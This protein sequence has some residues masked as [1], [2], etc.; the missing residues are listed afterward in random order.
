MKYLVQISLILFLVS[1]AKDPSLTAEYSDIYVLKI[2]KGYPYPIIPSDNPMTK[3]KIAL[4]KK[5][6]F[7][8]IL[9]R[10]ST[11]SCGSCHFQE[12]G[13]TDGLDKSV[14]I[15][16]GVTLRNVISL[17]NTAYTKS[18]FRDGG[19]STLEVQVLA[20]LDSKVEHDLPI[21]AA[22][23]KLNASPTYRALFDLVWK[24]EADAFTLTRSIAAFERTMIS[25]NSRYDQYYQG[26]ID[27]TESEKNGLELFFSDELNCSSCHTGLNFTNDDFINNGLYE[28][29]PIDSGRARITLS[30]DDVGKFKVPSL[31]NI[32]VTGPYMHDGSLKTLDEIIDHYASGGSNHPVKDSR[33]QGFSISDDEKDD[34]IAFLLSLT[35]NDFL[36]N[37]EFRK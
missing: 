21:G 17:T 23:A 29:Y 20:P 13:F 9:S 16:N 14:G 30:S 15:N 31:K 22:I 5:L 25:W 1:C 34:L 4:G 3:A 19:S 32:E 2:P 7:D 18:M 36:T 10:D 8:P 6:F 33:I 26:K 12:I 11:I 28:S 27:L 24:Q 35:D 37:P